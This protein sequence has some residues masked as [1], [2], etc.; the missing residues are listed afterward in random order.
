MW[1]ICSQEIEVMTS[2]GGTDL[3]AHLP[4]AWHKQL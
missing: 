1:F 4:M 3:A 2:L